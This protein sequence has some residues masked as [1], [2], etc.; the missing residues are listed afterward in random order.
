M[1]LRS[2]VVDFGWL[3]FLDDANEIG[4]I[5]HVAVMHQKTQLGFMRILIKMLDAPGIDRR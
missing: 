1:A 5:G 3:G 2:Q 4:R